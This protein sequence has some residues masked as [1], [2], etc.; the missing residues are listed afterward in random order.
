MVLISLKNE[1]CKGYSE[2]RDAIC[3][4]LVGDAAF[5]DSDIIVSDLDAEQDTITIFLGAKAGLI[6]PGDDANCIQLSGSI[7]NIC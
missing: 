3:Q 7:T 6:E 1:T 2:V 4:H 5:V